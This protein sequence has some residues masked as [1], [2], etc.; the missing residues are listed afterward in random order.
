MRENHVISGIIIPTN[1]IHKKMTII[2]DLHD[3]HVSKSLIRP[4]GARNGL[5]QQRQRSAPQGPAKVLHAFQFQYRS[6]IWFGYVWVL[7]PICL[8]GSRSFTAWHF[9]S[10]Y[11]CWLI[12]ET[13]NVGPGHRMQHPGSFAPC[14]CSRAQDSCRYIPGSELYPLGTPQEPQTSCRPRNIPKGKAP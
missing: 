7:L 2:K 5:P 4:S 9:L 14:W 11:F 13:P 6:K 3:F 1:D 12:G 8:S 10:P